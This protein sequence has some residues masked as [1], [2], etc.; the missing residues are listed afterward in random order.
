M[1]SRDPEDLFPSRLRNLELL[2]F[3]YDKKILEINIVN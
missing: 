2:E 1:T 3:S